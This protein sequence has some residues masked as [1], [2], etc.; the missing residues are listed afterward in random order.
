V[1][2]DCDVIE[3]CRQDKSTKSRAL[4]TSFIQLSSSSSIKLNK[5]VNRNEMA[6]ETT[7]ENKIKTKGKFDPA[8]NKT[9][10]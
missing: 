5:Q 8:F 3:E 2:V 9:M 4:D 6:K 1:P 7:T 10:S